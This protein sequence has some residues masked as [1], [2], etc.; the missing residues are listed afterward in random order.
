MSQ[1]LVW[2][3]LPNKTHPD[4]VKRSS[5]TYQEADQGQKTGVEEAVRCPS[6]STPEEKAGDHVSE[7]GP[8]GILFAAIIVGLVGH[9]AM[10][11][12]F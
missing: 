4:E 9:A 7:D 5:H 3:L 12:E 1:P 2:G 10:V 6:N 11:D 8:E